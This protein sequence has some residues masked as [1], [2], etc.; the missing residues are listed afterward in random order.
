MIK[1]IPADVLS[2]DVASTVAISEPQTSFAEQQKAIQNEIKAQKK[3][4][5]IAEENMDY[6]EIMG[7]TKDA[8]SAQ[9]KKAHRRMI[10]KW[11]PDKHREDAKF[12]SVGSGELC[13]C[14]VFHSCFLYCSLDCSLARS[15]SMASTPTLHSPLPTLH[16]QLPLLQDMSHKIS[17]AYNVLKE[18]WTRNLY[19]MFGL[20]QY[21]L[22]Q[23]VIQC[24]KSYMWNGI[25]ILKHSRGF[26]GIFSGPQK[27]KVWL[28]EE[29]DRICIGEKKVM[30]T[31]DVEKL[32]G[33]DAI[34][35]ELRV[36]EQERERRRSRRER[37]SVC[38]CE[39][40]RQRK[41]ARET[42]EQ[43]EE[44]QEQQEEEN[45]KQRLIPDPLPHQASISQT[46]PT[47]V[48]GSRRRC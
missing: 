5:K 48:E 21:L 12:A 41:Q 44:E 24:F 37:E 16:S 29:A 19:D 32:G 35:G 23:E 8:S 17:Q 20:E 45:Q 25:D 43:E 42:K 7:L 4:K 27:R 26:S 33:L 15:H 28:S 22:H 14:L 6:Y 47:C 40:E 2:G 39:R 11:H 10:M 34:K 18:A 46:S 9:V 1:P 38:V 36:G 3:A 31:E 13:R 30:D